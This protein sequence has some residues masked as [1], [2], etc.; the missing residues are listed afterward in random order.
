[1]V[2]ASHR[3]GF[4]RLSLTRQGGAKHIK[5]YFSFLFFRPVI[6][7]SIVF[8]DSAKLLLGLHKPFFAI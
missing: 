7:I 6:I 1:M 3:H 8:D 4:R 2:V 5:K